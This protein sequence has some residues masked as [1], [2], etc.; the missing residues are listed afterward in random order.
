MPE[1]WTQQ[2]RFLNLETHLGPDKLLLRS[3]RGEEGISR[4]FRFHLDMLAEDSAINFDDMIGQN[5]SFSVR[6]ADTTKARYFNGYVNRFI[7]FPNEERLTHYEAEVVP[8]LWF[9]TR[10][11]DCRIFQNMSVP[12]I[13]AKVFKDFGFTD[14]EDQ[15]RGTYDPWEYCVQYRETAF[16]F[17]SRLLESEGIFY[18]FRHENGKHTLVLG[19]STTAHSPCPEQSRAM[20]ERSALRGMRH[21]EDVVRVWKLEQE[22][23]PGKYAL[24][25]YNFETPGTRL[26]AQVQSQINQG[27]N[28]RFEIYDYPGEYEK[29]NQGD[30]L[31]KI[32]IEEQEAVHTVIHGEGDCRTFVSGFKFELYGADRRDQD[33]TYVLTSVT[34]SGE[35]GGI[36][37]G[38]GSL[39]ESSYSNTFTAMPSAVVFRPPRVAVKP[40]IHGTQTAVVVGPSGEE[41]YTDKY[42]RVKVQFFWDRLGKLDQSSSCWIRVAQ[43]VAGKSWGGLWTPRLGQEVVVSFLEGDPD[44]PLI[45]GSVYNAVQMPPYP[46]PDQQTKSTLKSYSSKG[47]GGFNE[48]RF[49]DK[50]GSEQIFVHGEKN[51]DARVKN[52]VFETIGGERHLIVEKDQFER[53]KGDQHLKVEQ[54]RNE[55]VG[56][57]VSLNAGSNIQEKVGQNYALDAGTEVHIK[58]GM[59]VVIESGTTLTLKVGGN[60]VN[61]NSGGV[62]IK[63]SMVMINSGGAA[64]SGAGS[65]PTGPKDPKEADTA[66]PGEKAPPPPPPPPPKQVSYSAKAAVLKQAAASGAPFCDI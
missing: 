27:G 28:T 13:V 50:K 19:D 49:E 57:T 41:I 53:V 1:K 10:T 46:M 14:F 2:D 54:D 24:C 16:N 11:A 59:N 31:T 23:R 8:W 40:L 42:G 30:G 34:H 61:I 55:K 43:A 63:G 33:G 4:L 18:F 22:L 12:D 47:G 32:R 21:E 37:S 48:I 39:S 66:K 35:E 60:F 5:V 7:Q 64:G 45:T 17:V 9:L 6:L 51:V 29:R 44:R 3:F 15:T 20:F 36:Y 25:D 38:A 62:F 52:S 26:D 65:S 56:G 58:A